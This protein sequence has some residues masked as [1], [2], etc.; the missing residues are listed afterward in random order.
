MPDWTRSMR[1]TFEYYIVDP[2]TWRDIKK[3]DLIESSSIT[4]DLTSNTKG[5]S[6]I[7][8]DVDF[9]DK[10]V[11]T[12][13]VTEQDG[14]REKFPLGTHLY[15]S[16]STSYK[17]TRKTASQDGYTPLVELDENPPPYG[18]SIQK[19]ASI[20][21]TAAIIAEEQ[22]RAPVIHGDNGDRLDDIF[23]SDTSD[24]YL[25][26]L[27]D[28]IANANYSFGLDDMGRIVFEKNQETDALAPIWT[29][30]D[31]NSSILYPDVSI[32]RDLYGIPNVVE[33]IYS[34]ANGQ[35][36][37][38]SAINSDPASPV[39]TVNRGRKVTYRDTNPNVVEGINQSQLESYARNRLKELSALEYTISYK[40][41]YCPV[42]IG[43]CVRLNY[44]MAGLNDVK[45]K[46]IRQIIN[47]QSGC[48]VEETA[49]FSKQLWG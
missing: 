25:T 23:V 37:V 30:N 27:T 18:F 11:R 38:A 8:S 41:G 45:A 43:N 44:K 3:L 20:L 5:T 36:I 4:R 22:A 33:V 24:T 16:P 10:Y 15:Q 29:Y 47:C 42:T 17:A 2:G 31:D 9:S 6:T 39:S 1:Q 21:G 35:P 46:V 34:P 13:L 28:L 32:D 19:G 48:S 14:R 26:F 49:V 12:Y 40:H 7:T